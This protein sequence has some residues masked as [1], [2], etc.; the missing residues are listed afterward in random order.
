MLQARF[1]AP[2]LSLPFAWGI[3]KLQAPRSLEHRRLSNGIP[4]AGV[5]KVY[6]VIVVQPHSSLPV[7]VKCK[8]R[9]ARAAILPVA[10]VMYTAI[11]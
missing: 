10:P 4:F 1:T 2:S 6:P 8:M 3:M 9:A 5:W 11:T 7:S